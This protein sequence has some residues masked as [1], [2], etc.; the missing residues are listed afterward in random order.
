M[1]RQT[2]DGIKE[3]LIDLVKSG[4][5]QDAIGVFVFFDGIERID[6]TMLEYFERME[7][8]SIYVN[9]F[10]SSSSPWSEYQRV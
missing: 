2:L 10:G 9:S 1:L 5:R 8:Q 3:N 4:V 7:N 6:K